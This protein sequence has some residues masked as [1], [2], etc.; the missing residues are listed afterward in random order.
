[1]GTSLALRAA[2]KTDP[3]RDPVVLLE[4]SSIGAGSSGES[5]AILRQLYA[6][7][8]LALMARD[9]M[10]EYASFETR[11]GRPIGYVRSGVLTLAG[12]EQPEWQERLRTM[13]AALTDS[14]IRIQLVEGPEIGNCF[15]GIEYRP[16]TVGAWEAEG[17]FVDAR[18][19]LDAFASLA[20]SYGAVTRLSEPVLELLVEDGRAVG[21]RSADVE[22][23]AEKVVVV[24]GPWSGP[25]LATAGY[26]PPLRIVQ[27]E[28]VFF[29]RD[30]WDTETTETVVRRVGPLSFD[31]EEERVPGTEVLSPRG[32]HPVLIDLELGAYFRSEPR[33]RRTR[34][35]RCSYDEDAEL[36]RPEDRAVEPLGT[37]REWAREALAKRL[38]DAADQPDG[39]GA[40]SWYTLTPD[41]Q[42]V[43]GPVPGVQ[44]LFVATGFSGHGFKLAPSVAEGLTQM[45]FDEPVTAFEPEFFDPGRFTGG[46]DWSGRFGL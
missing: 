32:V 3:I 20:R 27:P 35:G 11:V 15:P 19:T 1:M 30:D 14:G 42:P 18:L 12:P 13:V 45:L 2:Q 4:A 7:R 26:E 40:T 37:T 21:A 34:V 16:G 43:I 46:E 6:D 17:G 5:G 31:I 33:Q 25:L 39:G 29:A 36:A 22:Y 24:G 10:R 41:A 8:I 44:D 23:R 38:P 9:S 28:N